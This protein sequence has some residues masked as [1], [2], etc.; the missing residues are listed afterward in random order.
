MSATKEYYHEKIEQA[1]RMF[2]PEELRQ[3][4]HLH[5]QSRAASLVPKYDEQELTGM[6]MAQLIEI[7]AALGL[8]VGDAASR[9]NLMYAIVEKQ[10]S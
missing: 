3:V 7:A 1:S 8:T 10:A 6:N 9:P 2:T 4:N 5:A